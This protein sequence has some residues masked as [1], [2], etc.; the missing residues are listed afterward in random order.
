MGSL[1]KNRDCRNCYVTDLSCGKQQ[2]CRGLRGI[3]FSS[4]VFTLFFVSHRGRIL[5]SEL[6]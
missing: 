4:Y 6:A 3:Y 5:V 1:I 2:I